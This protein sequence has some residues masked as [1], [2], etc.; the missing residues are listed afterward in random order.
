M[1][2]LS[3]MDMGLSIGFLAL[4]SLFGSLDYSTIFSLSPFLNE[5]GITLIG[6]FILI[7]AMA[8]SAQ[9]PL[10]SWLPGSMEG[11]NNLK[12]FNLNTYIYFYMASYFFIWLLIF[13]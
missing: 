1:I 11:L 13:L 3:A 2:N 5:I 8:K 9:I 6:L 12:V 4:F 10:H 7:G